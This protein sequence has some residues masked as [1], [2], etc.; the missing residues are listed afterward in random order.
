V[1]VNVNIYVYRY[2]SNIVRCDATENKTSSAISLIRQ[3]MISI[4]VHNCFLFI[5]MIC[6]KL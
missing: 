3:V 2:G 4:S 5:L 6:L 1:Y